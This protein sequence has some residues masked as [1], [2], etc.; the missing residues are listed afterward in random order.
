MSEESKKEYILKR[1]DYRIGSIKDII[2]VINNT[3][4][5]G[6]LGVLFHLK[7]ELNLTNKIKE[8][9]V[10]FGVDSTLKLIEDEVYKLESKENYTIDDDMTHGTYV[11]MVA[12][13]TKAE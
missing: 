11:A 13:F 12:L 5:G 6:Y 2:T 4:S 10:T 9:L 8:H 3:D 7:D 1:L